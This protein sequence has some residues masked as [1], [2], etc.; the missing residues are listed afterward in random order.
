MAL[1]YTLYY[2]IKLYTIL[3]IKSNFEIIV[4]MNRLYSYAGIRELQRKNE[5]NKVSRHN[6]NVG[7]FIS[8]FIFFLINFELYG[9]K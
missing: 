6:I 4:N 7:P 3:Y 5:K 9:N 2:G 1:N 8:L